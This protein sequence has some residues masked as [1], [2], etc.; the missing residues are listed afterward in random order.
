M[1]IIQGEPNACRP[2]CRFKSEGEELKLAL[3]PQALALG[4]W[5]DYKPPSNSGIHPDPPN[6]W[7]GS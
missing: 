3:P 7:I 4:D 5:F 2:F 6:A 1:G